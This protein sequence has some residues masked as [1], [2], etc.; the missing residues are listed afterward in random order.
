MPL[1]PKYTG[2]LLMN[3][4]C[5]IENLTLAWRRVRS[6]I[7]VAR[8]R[9]SAG[10]DSVTL[11]D[12]EA[13]WTNQMTQLADELSQGVYRPLPP[14]W[15]A[16]PKRDGGAR[17]IAILAVRDRIAQRAVQ[18]VLEPVFD[19]LLLDCSYGCRPRVG[20]ADALAQ[21][22]RYAAQGRVWVVDADVVRYFDSIDQRILLG[23]V[24]QRVPETPVLRLIAQW[25]EVGVL[26][27][28]APAPGI[29]GLQHNGGSALLTQGEHL[30]RRLLDR[31]NPPAA[32]A[33]PMAPPDLGDPYAAATWDQPY[34][35]SN[36]YAPLHPTLGAP[37]GFDQRILT[38]LSLVKPTLDGV[39]HVLPHLQRIGG[40]RM[41]I[42]G[43][44]AAGAVA[45]GEPG[46]RW[47][48]KAAR[49]TPQG[50][51][52]SPL[53]ANIYLHPFDVALT[54]QGI[55]L[56][57]FMDDFVVMCASQDEAEHTL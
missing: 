38:A 8:R 6:N 3:Q 52:L 33:P 19:P 11:R 44:V 45:D 55:R 12:F 54:S 31:V 47:R 5:S 37:H 20:V 10:P 15:V 50:G 17:A 26:S 41:L 18:Q 57:R 49:G 36:P 24:R 43:A 13:D 53:L 48:G 34:P 30:V 46:L 32:P 16:I 39:R 22:E 25:L 23:L 9:T 51:A 28:S 56:V 4:I 42:A 7:R 29:D 27:E 1:F 21:A 35:G 14:R 40:Q 2:P